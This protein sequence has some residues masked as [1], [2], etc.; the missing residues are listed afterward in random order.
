MCMGETELQLFGTQRKRDRFLATLVGLALV[1]GWLT[2]E[3]SESL[4]LSVTVAVLVAVFVFAVFLIFVSRESKELWKELGVGL[5]AGL[6]LA[7]AAWMLNGALANASKDANLSRRQ[8]EVKL[9]INRDGQR[10][11]RA[12]DLAE[13]DLVG[14][15]LVGADGEPFDFSYAQLHNADLTDVDLQGAILDHADLTNA[16]LTRTNLAGASLRN[17]LLDG[18]HFDSTNM[19]GAVLR[20]ASGV[21]NEK[22][23]QLTA[24]TVCPGG[25]GDDGEGADR[26]AEW[27]GEKYSCADDGGEA[28]PP[29]TLIFLVAP[30]APAGTLVGKIDAAD[31]AG[32]DLAFDVTGRDRRR[33]RID[34]T[35][36][37]RLDEQLDATRMLQF[38]VRIFRT[39]AGG[40]DAEPA[41]AQSPTAA[42]P[43]I[44]AAADGGGSDTFVAVRVS[45]EGE[46]AAPIA[47]PTLLVDVAARRGARVGRVNFPSS[48]GEAG[49]EN[50]EFEIM[51][52][53]PDRLFYFDPDDVGLLR[54]K[55]A[56]E[57]GRMYSLTVKATQGT[58]STTLQLRVE[59]RTFNQAPVVEQ[60]SFDE[61]SPHTGEGVLVGSIEAIDPDGDALTFAADDSG[62]FDVAEGGEI[63]VGDALEPG[64]TTE[65]TVSVTDHG[66]P[67]LTTEATVT[68]T[69]GAAESAPPLAIATSPD[70]Y[71]LEPRGRVE[72]LDRGDGVLA[73]D[74]LP[75]DVEVTA[76]EGD[77]P[78][79]A[80]MFSGIG[81]NGTFTYIHNGSGRGDTFSYYA[82]AVEGSGGS[83]DTEVRL[84]VVEPQAILTTGVEASMGD[85]AG[86]L[87]DVPTDG[88]EFLPVRGDLDLFEVDPDTGVV[89]LLGSLAD[90][91]AISPWHY[92][93]VEVR[94]TSHPD[95]A[96]LVEV[97]VRFARQTTGDDTAPELA[98]AAHA[99]LEAVG[100]DCGEP[101]DYL[102]SFERAN[103]IEDGAGLP[104]VVQFPGC[105]A[106][107][108]DAT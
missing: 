71:V 88:L 93:T 101:A 72:I 73:N 68:I 33:V 36:E 30:R 50:R 2:Y 62:P 91:T 94:S 80:R 40:A 15:R 14:M 63:T 42:A 4:V 13:F 67:P 58:Y 59:A 9:A 28:P 106:A 18:A 107:A 64:T 45:V 95:S 5:A 20:G 103:G 41:A 51:G 21:D 44:C 38:C 66:V 26:R 97:G 84:V 100:R 23:L 1:A 79:S 81:P 98:R 86:P 69:T 76:T 56:V 47:H 29:P 108:A 24:G 65:F 87:A 39:E 89:R 55:R 52:G 3:K 102:A 48:V 35:G 19:A 8:T 53:D 6:V 7:L 10:S 25:E 57:A 75:P 49:D 16:D 70:V 78:A 37:I 104:D 82:R 92:L 27:N 12:E 85:E 31:P 77:L 96:V 83:F 61:L 90:L 99:S 54:L 11:F 105:P 22:G 17:A 43:G 46:D 32:E 60:Q 34:G 74:P